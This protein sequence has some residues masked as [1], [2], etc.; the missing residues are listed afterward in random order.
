MSTGFERRQFKRL[1]LSDDA[2]AVDGT[3]RELGKVRMVG[4][5]GMLIDAATPAIAKTLTPGDRIAVTIMEP[6]SQT[7]HSIDVLVRYKD[8]QQ[9]GVE[10]ITGTQ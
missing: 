6:K 4:G 8:G 7:S 5:G 2:Y 9:V 1:E 3:G 10:F